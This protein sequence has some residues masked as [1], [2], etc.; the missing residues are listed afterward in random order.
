MRKILIIGSAGA[1]KSV[2]SVRL[3]GLLQLPVLH[4]DA[5]HWLPGWERPERDQ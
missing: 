4:L 3:A 1:G 2:L 5:L